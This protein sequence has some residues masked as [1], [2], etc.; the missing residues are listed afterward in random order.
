MTRV[1]RIGRAWRHFR[2][3]AIAVV[4]VGWTTAAIAQTPAPPPAP[5]PARITIGYVDIDGDPR[6]E[7]IR[8]YERLILKTRDHPFAG[9]QVGI[10]EAKAVSRVLNTEF[11]LERITLKSADALVPAV[12]Q[13]HQNRG[14]QYFLIDAPAEVFKPL[15]AAVRGRDMLLFNFTAQDDSIRRE[16]CAREVVHTIPSLAMSMDAL[17]Q[18]LVSRKWRDVFVLQGPLP[19]DA[20]KTRAFEAS[21]K[22]FGL[23]IV[24]TKPFKAGTDPREREQNNPALLTAGG[25][26]YDVLFIAD[27][28]FDFARQVPY[29]MVRARP[30]VG[31]IDLEPQA[32]HWTWERNGAPQVNSRFQRLTEGR[33]M[34][35]ADWAAWIAV[36]MVVKSVQ[37]T[38]SPDFRTQRDFML[39]GAIFD[40]AKGLGVSVRPWDQQLRQAILLSAPYQ[41]VASAPVEGFLHK[42]NVLDTL[43]DDQADTPC[44]LAAP[45]GR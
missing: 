34:E 15:A 17:A 39:S 33:R 35:S 3:T 24:A 42:T 6:H 21:A 29:H 31:A 8:G 20:L 28:A 7:P 11:A 40:G 14:I 16:V 19:G 1:Q 36:K 38:T 10:L 37:G 27:E 4:A 18:Y 26:D 45:A 41:V 5:P 9:A 2:T 13:A 25:R 43:G 22:K 32:W 23:R 30:V 12:L 44:R